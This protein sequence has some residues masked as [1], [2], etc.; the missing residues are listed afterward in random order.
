VVDD[1]WGD[2]EHPAWVRLAGPFATPDAAKAVYLV[3]AL[4]QEWPNEHG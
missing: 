4:T 2:W 3:R 1:S